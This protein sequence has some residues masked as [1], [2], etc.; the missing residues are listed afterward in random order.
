M[1]VSFIV[2]DHTIQRIVVDCNGLLPAEGNGPADVHVVHLSE[3]FQDLGQLEVITI[4]SRC[5]DVLEAPLV[6]LDILVKE[7]FVQV[8]LGFE[9]E[10]RKTM[11]YCEICVFDL[12]YSLDVRSPMIFEF[13]LAF[14]GLWL[15]ED[16]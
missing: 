6:F 9:V 13:L 1:L 10:V 14:L 4:H 8:F 12:N 5:V 2:V 15:S 16:V 3:T 11:S 7:E